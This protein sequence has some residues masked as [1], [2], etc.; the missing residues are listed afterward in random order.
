MYYKVQADFRVP[1]LEKGL[2][3]SRLKW[4]DLAIECASLAAKVKKVPKLE[5]KV[6]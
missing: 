2:E 1:Q 6:D 4:A 3:E 5:V